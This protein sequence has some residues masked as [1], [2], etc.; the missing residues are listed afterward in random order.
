MARVE[1]LAE[2]AEVLERVPALARRAAELLLRLLPVEAP[3]QAVVEDLLNRRLLVNQV[4]RETYRSIRLTILTETWST[5][6]T[7]RIR[8]C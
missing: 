7:R 8:F 2:Q 4:F 5:C 6:A 3:A 1:A